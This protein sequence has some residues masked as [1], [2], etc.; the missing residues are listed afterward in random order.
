L[1]ATGLLE[2]IIVRLLKRLTRLGDLVQG[3]GTSKLSEIDP[4]NLLRPLQAAGFTYPIALG[5]RTSLNGLI[6]IESG[7]S[8]PNSARLTA[9]DFFSGWEYRYQSGKRW[10]EIPTLL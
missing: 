8:S 10:F 4:D 6:L 5:P 7:E 1:G 9:I 2:K 3:V